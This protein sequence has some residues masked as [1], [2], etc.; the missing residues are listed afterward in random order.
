M[1]ADAAVSNFFPLFWR[2]CLYKKHTQK[3]QH[4]NKSI[5]I[6]FILRRLLIWSFFSFKTD[7]YLSQRHLCQHEHNRLVWNLPLSLLSALIIYA[8]QTF[9]TITNSRRLQNYSW[10]ELNI[11]EEN[12]IPSQMS[13][14][15]LDQTK[16]D[17]HF[18]NV[19]NACVE[20]RWG[21]KKSYFGINLKIT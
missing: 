11:I 9:I 4:I 3:Q 12:S 17:Q 14:K 10:Y 15:I 5:V 8:T 13:S 20:V 18:H 2:T 6:I 19:S 7:S 1:S 21:K 16:N